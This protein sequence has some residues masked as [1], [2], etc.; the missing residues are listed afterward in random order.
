MEFI[1]YRKETKAE[2]T[3]GKVE[4]VKSRRNEAQTSKNCLSVE[5]HRI[6]LVSPAMSC[7]NAYEKSPTKEAP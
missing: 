7:D 6:Y 4:W 3:K 2:S 1:L 5:S